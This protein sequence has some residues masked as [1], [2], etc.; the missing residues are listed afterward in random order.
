[1]IDLTKWATISPR[2]TVTGKANRLNVRQRVSLASV[3]T[4][5]LPVSTSQHSR[6]STAVVRDVALTAMLSRALTLP[7]GVGKPR[8]SD[9][10]RRS[11]FDRLVSSRHHLP[12]YGVVL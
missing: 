1:M 12:P 7:I 8:A 4:V 3:E 2:K 11:I 5:R 6:T 10:I 9:F